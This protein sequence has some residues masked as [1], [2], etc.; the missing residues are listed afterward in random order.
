M[1]VKMEKKKSWKDLS[2]LDSHERPEEIANS[3]IHGIGAGLGAAALSLLVTFAGIMGD[4]YRVVSFAVYGTTLILLFTASTLYHGFKKTRI[5]RLFRIFDHAAIYLLIAGTYTPFLLV[6][7][8]G[9]IL[10]VLQAVYFLDRLKIVA[11]IAYLGMGLLILIAIKPLIAAL[12][13]GGFVW[14]MIG[15]ACY[16]LGIV[17]YVVKRIPFNHAVWHL[18]VLAG[19]IS[20]FFTMLLHVLPK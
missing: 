5:K 14:L 1:R 8:R 3:I 4:P 20:H 16:I 6:T 18:F 9:A 12:S 2:Q 19:A 7:I 11:L 13:L 17:F 15:G 10:G